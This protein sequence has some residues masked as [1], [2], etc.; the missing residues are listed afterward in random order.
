MLVTTLNDD[1]E[2]QNW[3]WAIT[4]YQKLMNTKKKK[5][6]VEN[7]STSIL[8]WIIKHIN[9]LAPSYNI[10]HCTSW[11]T[12]THVMTCCFMAPIH[13]LNKCLLALG[14][15]QSAISNKIDMIQVLKITFES[16]ISKA[17]GGFPRPIS[18]ELDRNQVQSIL[19][20]ILM[21]S[22]VTNGKLVNI[23]LSHG[24]TRTRHYGTNDYRDLWC[25]TVSSGTNVL[26]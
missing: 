9:W 19:I 18:L 21:N 7:I 15:H 6:R 26:R 17:F 10:W 11:V 1:H 16:F 23:D 20:Q 12:F 2:Y 25:I 24:L 8:P 3:R 22:Q 13:Y 5:K 14:I 4:E